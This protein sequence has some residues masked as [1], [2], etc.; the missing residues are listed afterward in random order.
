MTYHSSLFLG[1][2]AGTT[3]LSLI[4]FDAASCCVVHRLTL[5]SDSCL[6]QSQGQSLQN[7][8]HIADLAADAVASVLDA[9]PDVSAIGVTGQMHGVVCLDEDGDPVSPL[10]TWQNQLADEAVCD[11][12]RCK[13]GHI[14]HPGYG[15]ATLYALARAG[16]LPERAR[17]YGTIMD[18]I[19]MR[20][21]G[22]KTPLMHATNAASLGL[23]DMQAGCLDDDALR[24]LNLLP[25]Q[26]PAVT[27]ASMIAGHHRGIPVS[28]AIG[29]NQASFFGSVPDE[30]HSLLLNY[31][32]GS[33]LS[34]VCASPDTPGGEI[35]PY[36]N[37]QYLLCRSA[38]CGGRAYAMLER[39]FSE[40]VS[41]AGYGHQS[42]YETLNALAEEAYRAEKKLH[43][44]TQF[45]GTREDPTLR[46]SIT[47]IDEHNFTPGALAL[48][49]LQGMADELHS[50]FDPAAH[51][52]IGHLIAS[53]NAVRKNP[54]LRRL[55]QDTF[56]MPLSLPAHQEEA[57]LGAALFGG[58]CAGAL[59]YPQAK[60]T[61][62][63]H[64]N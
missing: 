50:G 5:L 63:L 1:V 15:H 42:H 41:Q 11:E 35:R 30:A 32:I 27:T 34:L 54:M 22:Q 60:S 12:I 51:P 23:W 7:P 52:R 53:G 29:D 24:A 17:Q 43:V 58:V 39:F 46:G 44:N 49:V 40:F 8:R 56:S 37:G 25:L 16:Q 28:V 55:L 6:P 20:L 14:I 3:T 57:A 61:I 21:T 33:Q 45:C 64:S 48:G 2:D 18:Y 62:R 9:F 31:G 36:L 26:P 13:T 19:V 38:L 59:G 4:L 10:Y 47:C